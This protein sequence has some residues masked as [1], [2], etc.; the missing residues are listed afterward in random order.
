MTRRADAHAIVIHR[1]EAKADDEDEE[2]DDEEGGNVAMTDTECSGS[3]TEAVALPFAPVKSG[4]RSVHSR[5]LSSVSITCSSPIEFPLKA[6]RPSAVDAQ[7][8]G[9]HVSVQHQKQK[10]I[11]PIVAKQKIH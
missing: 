4:S 5:E 7:L 2:E 10:K 6:K 11:S 1:D 9:A 8:C 3:A